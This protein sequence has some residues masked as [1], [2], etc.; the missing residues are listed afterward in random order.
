VRRARLADHVVWERGDLSWLLS[1]VT[2]E[3]PAEA[4]TYFTPLALAWEDHDEERLKRLTAGGLAKVRQQA[5]VG[6]LGDA[7]Y[8]EAFCRAVL[9]AIGAGEVV[10]TAAGRLHFR[11]T[12]AFGAVAGTDAATLPVSRPMAQS[13]NTVVTFGER[14]FLKGYRRL[15]EGINPELEIG[16]YLT[17]VARF[18]HC[19]PVAG[20]L[21]H[22]DADGRT[23]TLALVQ[24]Y[25]ANQ[26]DGWVYTHDY[27]ERHLEQYRGATD[28]V[29]PD[30]HGG[31]LALMQA[32]GH[33]TAE[34][35]R[36]FA[37]ASGDPAFEPEAA[38]PQDIAAD[39]ARAHAG[40][41]S[42]LEMLAARLD[43]LPALARDEAV[44]LLAQ[45]DALQ[46]RLEACAAS[47][48]PGL[49]TRLHGDYHLGQV[50]V[51][52]ND[53]VI[54]DFEGEPARG[55]EERRAK[56]SPL[57]DVAGMLRSFSYVCWSALRRVAHNTEQLEALAPLGRDW[58]A[59]TRQ[60]FLHAYAEGMETASG[61]SGDDATALDPA[62]GLLG[63]FELEK[64]LYELRYELG[65]RPDWVGVPLRGIAELMGRAL[66]GR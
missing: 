28:T 56:Q 43:A 46:A 10:P 25:V 11:A 48:R 15:R 51:T 38:G 52:R 59:K 29:P 64:A 7:F 6:V 39:L 55:S 66:P 33:R 61:R 2:L 58:E 42:G 23:M 54:I 57:R 44:A 26:G 17:E 65:N 12:A 62:E 34:L 3:G 32:L 14:V 18:P 60:T 13:S 47:A 20:A 50:L 40:L 35:H 53:F 19:V 27:L 63:L 30:A 45:R 24:A 8:D 4:S 21:E 22:V 37:L 5:S 9:L 41:R 49:K 1:I 36:A 16:R 31:F